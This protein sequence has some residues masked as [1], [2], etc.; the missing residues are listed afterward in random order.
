M[1]KS[2]YTSSKK[3]LFFIIIF[4]NLLFL[5]SYFINKEKF[6]DT[7]T[8]YTQA[9]IRLSMNADFE[10]FKSEDP[11]IINNSEIKSKGLRDWLI[12]EIYT[13]LFYNNDDGYSIRKDQRVQEGV[14]TLYF[15]KK[16]NKRPSATF[17]K[18][19]ESHINQKLY[20]IIDRFKN[21]TKELNYLLSNDDNIIKIKPINFDKTRSAAKSALFFL[22]LALIFNLFFIYAYTYYFKI[23]LFKK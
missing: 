9:F 17:L 7:Y 10:K 6:A 23:K 8:I 4:I 3:N 16:I 11:A 21:K 2:Q 18:Q 14:L 15:K 12:R 20:E 1:N 13:T 5:T 19:Q 22:I